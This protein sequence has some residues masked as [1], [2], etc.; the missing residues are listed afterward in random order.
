MPLQ[1]EEKQLYSSSAKVTLLSI[2]LLKFDIPYLKHNSS[3]AFPTPLF[4]TEV[5]D[6]IEYRITSK[7]S[8]EIVEGA[9]EIDNLA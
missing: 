7:Y 2:R 4:I 5:I 8:P 1:I 6:Q 3:V 9:I